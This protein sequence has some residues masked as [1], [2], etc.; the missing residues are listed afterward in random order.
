MSQHAPE[1]R[2]AEFDPFTPL[3]RDTDFQRP[4]YLLLGLPF[5]AIDMATAVDQVATAARSGRRFLLSTPNLNWLI[6]CQRDEAFRNSVLQSELSL[7]DGMPVVWLARLLGLPLR[8]RV[9]GSDL[10]QH[11]RARPISVHFFGGPPGFAGQAC[12]NL[13]RSG[14]PMRCKGHLSPGFG[15]VEEMSDP[16]TLKAINASGADFL[17]VALGARKGQAWI[18][19]N[20]DRLRIPVVSHLGAVVNFVA[21]SVARAPGLVG[22]LGLEWLWRIKEEPGLWRRYWGD[23]IGFLSY[24]LRH[25]L[26]ALILSRRAP[27][28]GGELEISADTQGRLDLRLSGFWGEAGLKPLREALADLNGRPR[29]VRLDLGGVSHL[30]SAALGLLALLRGHQLKHQ[31]PLSFVGPSPTLRRRLAHFGACYLLEPLTPAEWL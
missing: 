24:L 30:D 2:A 7:P 29:A 19:R 13:N 10:F 5:D 12:E 11:L 1:A 26:P 31:Q 9:P 16:A 21:G 14:D 22:K 27:S 15:G 3:E 25:G 8:Q 18:L 6:T 17:V 28:R 23:G 4:V 20:L